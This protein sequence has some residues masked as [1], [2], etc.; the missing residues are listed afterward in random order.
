MDVCTFAASMFCNSFNVES[1][2]ILFNALACAILAFSATSVAAT[3]A[4]PTPSPTTEEMVR[5]DSVLA[6]TPTPT[7]RV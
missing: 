4:A 1:R 7:A 2:L 5:S 6:L 3:V